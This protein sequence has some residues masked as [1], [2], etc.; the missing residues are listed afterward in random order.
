MLVSGKI[1]VV[2][3]FM[4]LSCVAGQSGAFDA[5][6]VPPMPPHVQYQIDARIDVNQGMIEGTETISFT[7]TAARPIKRLVLYWIALGTLDISHNEQPVTVLDCIEDNSGNAHTH[8][9]LTES[10]LPG[11]SIVLDLTFRMEHPGFIQINKAEIG[12]THRYIRRLSSSHERTIE[13]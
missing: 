7:N 6:W 9:A 3:I 13:P 12:S 11:E 1:K 5:F 10:V 8:I 2:F 4:L